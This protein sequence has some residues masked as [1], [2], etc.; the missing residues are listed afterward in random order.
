[1]LAIS[2][3]EL[4]WFSLNVKDEILPA[5]ISLLSPEEMARADRFRFDR[6]RRRYQIAHGAIRIILGKALNALPQ[7]IRLDYSE[8][9]KPF[10]SPHCQLQGLQFNL[11]HSE[12]LAIVGI[13]RDRLIGVD[14]EYQR[15]MDNLESLVK[16]FFSREE[17]AYFQQVPPPEQQQLFFQLWTAKEAYLKATGEGLG[18]GLDRV[19]L[20]LSPLAFQVLPDQTQ[21]V[22]SWGLAF[23]TLLGDY[24]VAIA[25]SPPLENSDT[26]KRWQLEI[27]EFLFESS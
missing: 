16:R 22:H 24:Q 17:Y 12:D 27:K 10:L 6:H 20:S 5:L 13:S 19:Q 15:E 14:V 3:V 8:R 25:V 7:S 23:L 9:G 1:M 4:W 11:S 2:Q 26:F 18:V 21:K